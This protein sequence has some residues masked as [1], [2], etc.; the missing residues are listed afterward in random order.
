MNENRTV[1]FR[2]GRI[3]GTFSIRD[4]AAELEEILIDRLKHAYCEIEQNGRL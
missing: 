4:G 2:R 1:I 3:A